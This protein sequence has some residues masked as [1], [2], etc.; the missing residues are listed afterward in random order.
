MS[1]SKF[2]LNPQDTYTT[3]S[4]GRLYICQMVVKITGRKTRSN[5]MRR[6]GNAN[7]MVNLQGWGRRMDSWEGPHADTL[8]ETRGQPR[9][10]VTV[11]KRDVLSKQKASPWKFGLVHV[12]KNKDSSAGGEYGRGSERGKAKIYKNI[13][14][15]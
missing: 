10:T 4:W 15:M 9:S 8:E 11:W 7:V 13:V 6:R 2:I 1:N 14:G 3:E 12:R 5:K